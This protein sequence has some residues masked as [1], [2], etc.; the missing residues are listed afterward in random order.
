MRNGVLMPLLILGEHSRI[1]AT[2][3]GS[4]NPA[5]LQ[6]LSDVFNSPVFAQVSRFWCQCLT[7]NPKFLHG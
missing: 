6:V 7:F 3:G 1:I 2:G 5:M 4:N